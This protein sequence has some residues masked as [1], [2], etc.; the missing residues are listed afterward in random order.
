MKNRTSQ[1]KEDVTEIGTSFADLPAKNNGQ[2]GFGIGAFSPELDMIYGSGDHIP[3]RKPR[4][5]LHTL[6]SPRA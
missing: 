6:Y 5:S 4:K 3:L 1:A 2:P